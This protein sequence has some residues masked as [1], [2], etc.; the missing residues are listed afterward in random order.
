MR[1]LIYIPNLG[2]TPVSSSFRKRM[3]GKGGSVLLSK[4]SGGEGSSYD[5][6]DE[7]MATTGRRVGG[8][9]MSLNKKLESLA[10]NT[11]KRPKV[12]N[13]KFNL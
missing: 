3:S 7:Y 5:S 1:K 12:K 6:V 4:G 13:I 8:S 10:M 9:G 2:I 11:Q